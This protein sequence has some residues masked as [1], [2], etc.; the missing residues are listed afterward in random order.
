[1]RVVKKHATPEQWEALCNDRGR[2]QSGHNA[3]YWL[4][5][6]EENYPMYFEDT[7]DDF[8]EEEEE[9]EDN[10]DAG[11]NQGGGKKQKKKDFEEK[12]FDQYETELNV[13]PFFMALEVGR[14]DLCELLCPA[15]FGKITF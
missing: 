4:S 9:E 6:N 3:K 10:E 11:G 13:R 12:H 14:F 7:N 15:D 1:M 2:G 5:E 8:G